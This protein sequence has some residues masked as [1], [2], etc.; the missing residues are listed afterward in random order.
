[1]PLLENHQTADGRVKLPKALQA[2]DGE[3]ISLSH[4]GKATTAPPGFGCGS[5]KRLAPAAVVAPVRLDAAAGTGRWPAGAGHPRFRCAR[6]NHPGAAP[7]ARRAGWRVHGWEMGVNWGARADTVERLRHRLDEIRRRAGA[8]GRLEP[9][10]TVR[11]ELA[12]AFPERVRAVVTLGSPFSGDP[13]QNNVWRIYERIARHKVDDPPIPRIT[14][15]PP[16]PTLALWSRQ[17]RADRAARRRAGL[18]TSA[19]RRSS[20]PARTWHSAFPRRRRAMWC[21]K[22]TRFLEEIELSARVRPID[23]GRRLAR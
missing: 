1:M 15:K 19:T 13:K 12:R 7:G 3:R 16:V 17:G 14:A 21:A 9:G 20:S 2:A 10:R 6:P 23:S 18:K 11:A 4:S 5:V 22:S 8:A